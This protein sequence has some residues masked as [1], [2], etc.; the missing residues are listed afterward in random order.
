VLPNIIQDFQWGGRRHNEKLHTFMT[1]HPTD[2]SISFHI[3]G[4]RI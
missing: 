1:P 3:E 4:V 2:F